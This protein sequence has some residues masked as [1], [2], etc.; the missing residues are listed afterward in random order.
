MCDD[1]ELDWQDL[2]IAGAL[3]EELADE[4]VERMR[5]EQLFPEDEGLD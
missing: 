1:L 3:A 5:L 2:A 4:E